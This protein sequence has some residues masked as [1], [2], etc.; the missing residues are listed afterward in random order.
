[1]TLRNTCDSSDEYFIIPLFVHEVE[2]ETLELED[3]NGFEVSCPGSEDGRRTVAATGGSSDP[4]YLWQ[5]TLNG[6]PLSGDDAS[7]EGLGSGWLEAV[8]SDYLCR[9][10][11][12]QS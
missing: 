4:N 9:I 7:I 12:G 1:M 6:E 5:W 8:V 10:R 2:L 11:R 3:Y